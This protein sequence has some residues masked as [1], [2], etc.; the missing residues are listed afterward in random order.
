MATSVI[1][2]TLARDLQ[3]QMSLA[4]LFCHVSFSQWFSTIFKGLNVKMINIGSYANLAL[5]K[6]SCAIKLSTILSSKVL[7]AFFLSIVNF[8]P[9]H[10]GRQSLKP[11]WP[12]PLLLLPSFLILTSFILPLGRSVSLLFFVIN[13]P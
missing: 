8:C 10:H 6:S 5:D 11:L 2:A 13:L 12:P 4:N 1:K 3:K 7:V 9:P